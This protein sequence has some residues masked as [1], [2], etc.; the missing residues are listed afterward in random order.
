MEAIE[1]DILDV[2]LD[3]SVPHL[4]AFLADTTDFGV[5]A[6]SPL[7]SGSDEQ[8]APRR[9]R[10]HVDRPKAEL[11]YLRTKHDE[12]AAQ[13]Q[14]LQDE[15]ASMLPSN[16]SPWRSRAQD[17]AHLTQ[18]CLQE[19]AC[20]KSHVADQLKVIEALEKVLHKRPKVSSFQTA[21]NLWRQCILAATE[22][23]ASLEQLLKHQ[24]ERLDSEWIRLG[25][26]DN[27]NGAPLHKMFVQTIDERY[28]TLNYAGRMTRALD[29]R[30]MSD[31]FWDFKTG[32]RG[33][34]QQ[35]L[36]FFHP[37]LIYSRYGSETVI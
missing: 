28:V 24:Y 32:K 5:V 2:V 16:T 14:V 36:Q 26:Y 22:R 37:R 34:S 30:G 6:S 19:N 25:M 9:K 35:I 29:F 4:S 3:S 17:Q 18:R 7:S 21:T 11:L 15:S 23:E 27:K 10:R 12:L 31:V 33:A 8:P 20:L 13:L 1:L